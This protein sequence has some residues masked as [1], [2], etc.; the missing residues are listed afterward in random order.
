MLS[1][2]SMSAQVSDKPQCQRRTVDDYKKALAHE[3][4]NL[5][6]QHCKTQS[7]AAASSDVQ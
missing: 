5:A 2:H 1:V 3:Q 6:S 4:H 7:L